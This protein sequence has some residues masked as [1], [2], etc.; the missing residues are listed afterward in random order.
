MAGFPI[1]I[2]P[3]ELMHTKCI[4]LLEDEPLTDVFNQVM[5]TEEQAFKLRDLIESF[6]PRCPKDPKN[7]FHM[8]LT[9]DYQVTIKDIPDTYSAED[10]LE[11]EAEGPHDRIS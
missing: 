2:D 7:H 4:V 6:M 11:E 3:A 1:K 10:I 8:A 5:L 9:D